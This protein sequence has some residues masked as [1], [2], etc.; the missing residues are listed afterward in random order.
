M[1]HKHAPV[2]G[3]RGRG[4]IDV[5]DHGLS[6]FFNRKPVAILFSLLGSSGHSPKVGSL[7]GKNV[8]SVVIAALDSASH[9]KPLVLESKLR[10]FWC[11]IFIGLTRTGNDPMLGKLHLFR[12]F[13]KRHMAAKRSGR[14]APARVWF[15][16]DQRRRNRRGRPPRQRTKPER[17]EWAFHR[18]CPSRH[19]V[20][21]RSLCQWACCHC[22]NSQSLESFQ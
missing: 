21:I 20:P 19:R 2:G 8:C 3:L 10:L 14:V 6:G 5:V 4:E 15:I 9:A 13:T 22:G 11:H 18:P 17:S 16:A 7:S 12:P 1:Q